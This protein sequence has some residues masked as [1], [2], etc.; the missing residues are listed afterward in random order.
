MVSDS[1]AAL[2][3]YLA[4]LAAARIPL[5]LHLDHVASTPPAAV[6]RIQRFVADQQRKG[7]SLEQIVAAGRAELP[8]SYWDAVEAG[9][10]IN[11]LH[12]PFERLSQWAAEQQSSRDRAFQWLY[13]SVVIVMALCLLVLH[14]WRTIPRLREFAQSL[15]ADT[16]GTLQPYEINTNLWLIL[17]AMGVGG[18]GLLWA[19]SRR[20]IRSRDTGRW[21]GSWI[22]AIAGRSPGAQLWDYGRLAGLMAALVEK[23]VPL[24]EA[25]RRSLGIV[26]PAAEQKMWQPL[27][28]AIDTP[29]D[30]ASMHQAI[31]KASPPL[32]R[33]ALADAGGWR[34]KSEALHTAGHLYHQLAREQALRNRSPLAGWS[35]FAVAAMV[36]FAY[37]AALFV[38]FA[39]LLQQ[40]GWPTIG[41]I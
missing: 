33:I 13:P 29:A 6:G 15:A 21:A 7:R 19:L 37:A 31:V 24:Q 40:L 20:R 41:R 36:T 10:L 32:L 11:R 17:A 39:S 26:D 1:L 5:G 12:A 25:V 3:E 9:R 16:P 27:R 22:D 28:T 14:R 8:S 35:L 18:I 23:E 38:P 30:E 4:A 2:N 34:P